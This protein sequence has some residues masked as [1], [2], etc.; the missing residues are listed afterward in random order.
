MTSDAIQQQLMTLRDGLIGA[1][2]VLNDAPLFDIERYDFLFKV[3]GHALVI[4]FR[5]DIDYGARGVNVLRCRMQMPDD[6]SGW[7]NVAWATVVES[8]NTLYVEPAHVIRLLN[9]RP[10]VSLLRRCDDLWTA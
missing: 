8:V 5:L 10:I 3:R 1:V 6:R 9:G 4:G 7:F 2:I